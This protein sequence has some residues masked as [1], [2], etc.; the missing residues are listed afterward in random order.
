[1]PSLK[2]HPQP[3]L[4][5]RPTETG[6]Y[7]SF[8]EY[9][10]IPSFISSA[11]LPL[12]VVVSLSTLQSTHEP[13]ELN[14]AI[15]DTEG[16]QLRRSSRILQPTSKEKLNQEL[17]EEFENQL[18]AMEEAQEEQLSQRKAMVQAQPEIIVRSFSVF[19]QNVL[20][21]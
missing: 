11:I 3:P 21:E 10:T 13:L 12:P 14:L 2:T 8:N 1:M 20:L 4:N 6:K 19:S 7:M 17:T 15:L 18:S 9:I 5:L 16:S